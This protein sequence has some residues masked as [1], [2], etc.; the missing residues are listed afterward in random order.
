MSLLCHMEDCS[1]LSPGNSW[2]LAVPRRTSARSRK[3]AA[4]AEV[5]VIVSVVAWSA[6]SGPG[7]LTVVAVAVTDGCGSVCSDVRFS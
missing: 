2:P 3:A 1:S 5:L 7:W 6:P 4:D